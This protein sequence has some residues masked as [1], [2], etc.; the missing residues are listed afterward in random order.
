[1]E[2]C[3]FCKIA[4]KEIPALTVYEDDAVIAFLDIKPV[5]PGHVLVVPKVHSAGLHDA[6]PETLDRLGRAMQRIAIG[7]QKA[8]EVDGFNIEQNNG[9]VAGQ[10][11]PHLHFNIIP[12]R[13]DDGLKHWPG[14]EYMDGVAGIVAEKIQSALA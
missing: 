3:L 7:I 1:M 4:S 9:A 5:V 13:S 6:A 12:R 11:I 14:K 10:V 8:L 2:D